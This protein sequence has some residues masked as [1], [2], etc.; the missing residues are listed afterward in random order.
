[1]TLSAAALWLSGR[2]PETAAGRAAAAPARET[3]APAAS[4]IPLAAQTLERLRSAGG[5]EVKAHASP[6]TGVYDFV[7]AAGGL[8]A[9]LAAD[10]PL[11]SPESRARAFLGNFGGLF[12]MTE[13]ERR[14]AS[15]A[16][17]QTP[18]STLQLARVRT[19]RL[20]TTHV[21]FDQTYQGMKV[22]GGQLVVHLN[23][24]GVRGVNG[25]FV[26]GVAVGKTPKVSAAKAQTTALASL[27]KSPA[28]A[29]L[30]VMKTEL[31]VYRLGLLE[32]Y[33][34]RNRL[35]H[36]VTVGNVNGETVQ[37]F[38]D[39]HDGNVLNTISLTPHALNRQVY[40]KE[41]DGDDSK[42]VVKEGDTVLPPGSGNPAH[43][44]Y[45]WAGQTY[46]LMASGF[47]FD[48]FDQQ[49]AT[50]RTVLILPDDPVGDPTRCPNATWNGSTTNYC[51]DIDKDDVVA[52]EWG[53]A[54]TQYTHNL[55]YSYQSGA[56][57][58]SYSDI[59][60]EALDLLN[61]FDARGGANNA[62]PTAYTSDGERFVPT[63]GGV[64]W[65]VGEDVAGLN[66]PEALGIF[67]D[68][69][70]PE[71]FNDP[72]HVSD[73]FYACG[74][75]DGGGVH[76][77]SGVPNHAF[78][79]LVDGKT[80]NGVT[81]EGIGLVRALNIYVRAMDVYQ[82]SSTNF[83]QHEQAL[84]ASC[85]DLVGLPLNNL[86]T[87]SALGTVAPGV[88][89]TQQTCQ[90][91]E[92]AMLAV[93]MG[94][95][96]TQCG[97]RKL[98]D[99]NTPEE[100]GGSSTV[101]A[102]DWE[103]GMD[104][105]TLGNQGAGDAWPGTDW[106]LRSEL[107]ANP[108][109]SARA[110]TAAFA[111]NPQIGE[112]NG[113]T[114]QV[115]GDV[116][117]RFWMDSP[118]IT[119]PAGASDL[120]LA[121]EHFVQTE[122]EYDGGNVKLSVNGGPFNVIP[123]EKYLFNAPN[124]DIGS[125]NPLTDE[126]IWNGANGGSLHGSWG[127]T[128]AD[129]AGLVAP[130]DKIRLRFDWG[131]DACNGN[132]GWFVDTVR[133]YSCPVLEAPALSL[134]P[135]YGGPDR[136]G[137]YTLN[138]TRP[139]GATGPDVVQESTSCGPAFADDAEEQ[140]STGL[141]AQNSKWSGS[142][143]WKSVP[144]GD[145]TAYFIPAGVLQN[146]SL[147][148]KGAVAIPAGASAK[149][150]FRTRQGLEDGYDYAYV[151]ASTDG[152]ANYVALASYTGPAEAVEP[153]AGFAGTRTID[154]T[155]L[156]GQTVKLRFRL[157]SDEYTVGVPAGWY[158]DDIAVTASTF[159][160][161]ATVAGNSYTFTKKPDGNFCYRVSTGYQTPA[162]VAQSPFSNVA[163]VTVS[164]VVCLTNVAAGASGASASASSTYPNGG[165]A[166]ATA[167]DGDRT[168]VNWG[169]GGGWADATR[170]A[171]PD[172]L[173]VNFGGQK[174]VHAINVYTLQNNYAAGGQPG[175]STSA[176]TYGLLD[177]DVQYWDG[178]AWQT[179]PQP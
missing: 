110:G 165:F 134:G 171:Y 149:L 103:T 101:Y 100:C 15:G 160:D 63:G 111:I 108:D 34:G 61:G 53:H 10:N 30:R 125:N 141:T 68:M 153:T 22:L 29:T 92:R 36:A 98:L 62:Q 38:V 19:D 1:L 178:S 175:V 51:P 176:T 31:A 116:S 96:P 73:R 102:E 136:D 94:K 139:A 74:T 97:F 159:A 104:G 8:N 76:T 168:G 21:K 131:Q 113:G 46:N 126:M 150:T 164:N 146:E 179:V 7:Q 17:S 115:G 151:E 4:V 59:F 105:W 18:G 172:W 117:G 24:F 135:D 45:H 72:G 154:L 35:A 177:Y 81:V 5:R 95:E 11:A 167:I 91:V 14:L 26:P 56:L 33:K 9:V 3:S 132:L 44:L 158:V 27:R 37:V 142:P 89:I 121:F 82:V 170:D 145:S 88:T 43:D 107:P 90:Q 106:A 124:F 112:P 120:K 41:Y 20:G 60:G 123:Q 71:A 166:A 133:L 93:E 58:E 137:R 25:N 140:L 40:V 122:L 109:G 48:S 173:E 86:S 47:G 114:C 55:I 16:A 174:R 156:A 155:P 143:Q 128:I 12:G 78:A 67:R 119:V 6:R 65:R 52:H 118:E 148:M 87:T 28:D 127:T 49:G 50:M 2:A 144:E 130:G 147:T 66:Q 152:G 75:G 169:A 77:N 129:L 13:A 39:A 32:G 42:A 64:R 69:W 85:Q 84:V 23:A 99:P 70:T 83:A 157:T 162:G 138:W 79:M 80:Y 54:Y 163:D 161:V 57:N